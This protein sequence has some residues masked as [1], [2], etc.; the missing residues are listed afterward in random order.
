MS[1][2]P[3][4]S[5]A[6]VPQDNA[7]SIE[8]HLTASEIDQQID[9]LREILGQVSKD[10]KPV[11]KPSADAV[12]RLD[13]LLEQLASK[14]NSSRKELTPEQ[15]AETDSILD[16]L[17]QENKIPAEIN[18][19]ATQVLKRE[20]PP[21]PSTTH[22]QPL[23]LTQNENG[24]PP[25]IPPRPANYVPRSQNA[26]S[27][28]ANNEE[29]L[30]PLPNR[31][32]PAPSRVQ[33]SGLKQPLIGNAK[34]PPKP[35]EVVSSPQQKNSE[36]PA[37][38]TQS[39]KDLGFKAWRLLSKVMPRPLVKLACNLMIS[40]E[41]LKSKDY[42][43]NLLRQLPSKLISSV[44]PEKLSSEIVSKLSENQ[45]SALTPQ[46]LSTPGQIENLSNEQVQL[47]TQNQLEGLVFNGKIQNMTVEQR[48]SL[49]SAQVRDVAK[50]FIAATP[51]KTS[52]ETKTTTYTFNSRQLEFF[53]PLINKG[54][55]KNKQTAREKVSAELKNGFPEHEFSVTVR[56]GIEDL[57]KQFKEYRAP[58]D[59]GESLNSTEPYPRENN[60][61]LQ[62]AADTL[63]SGLYQRENLALDEK[64][65]EEYPDIRRVAFMFEKADLP[66]SKMDNLRYTRTGGDI[67]N[68]GFPGKGASKAMVFYGV[69][70]HSEIDDNAYGGA[71]SQLNDEGV[72]KAVTVLKQPNE[73]NIMFTTAPNVQ[74][75]PNISKDQIKDFFSTVFNNY[76]MI[77]SQHKGSHLPIVQGGHLGTGAFQN[78]V[79]LSFLLQM[80][81]AHKVGVDLVLH[82]YPTK[83]IHQQRA[84]E[85]KEAFEKG[86]THNGEQVGPLKTLAEGGDW[87]AFESAVMKAAAHYKWDNVFDRIAAKND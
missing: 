44:P 19:I 17:E 84:G 27:P 74:L 56:A 11:E 10:V 66:E 36:K 2:T 14:G 65:A 52:S 78:S 51:S 55:V 22:S 45:F 54:A 59:H 28:I 5:S 85:A 49:T 39:E 23:P 50:A 69:Q 58:A 53:D 48:L 82:D 24:P 86:F 21:L 33:N 57:T 1:S 40:P 71:F 29:K 30:P 67:A 60:P 80:A 13:K 79:G 63:L 87:E 34:P 64:F 38:P 16:E 6:P 41:N 75:Q 70:Q 8:S 62:N 37:P 20:D 18:D 83:Q 43:P 81:A 32:P 46:Q 72:K 7:Q 4:S 35:I 77:K 15:L 31:A 76:A 12:E 47:L 61:Y 68:R 73:A 42:D 25:P 26:S 9:S 3:I